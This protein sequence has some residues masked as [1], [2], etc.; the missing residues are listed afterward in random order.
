MRNK[1]DID[2]S[3]ESHFASPL[4]PLAR[5][6]CMY[7]LYSSLNISARCNEFLVSETAYYRKK[8]VTR[9]LASCRVLYSNTRTV[10]FFFCGPFET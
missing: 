7:V 2:T 6:G 8:P 5:I 10:S 1:D 3:R 9:D 4:K